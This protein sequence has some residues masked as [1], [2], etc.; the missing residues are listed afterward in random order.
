VEFGRIGGVET[1]K[2][3]LLSTGGGGSWPGAFNDFHQTLLD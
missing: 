2:V 1:T 3:N